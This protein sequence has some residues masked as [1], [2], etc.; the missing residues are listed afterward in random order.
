[1]NRNERGG[2]GEGGVSGEMLREMAER[3]ERGREIQK[4]DE[5]KGVRENRAAKGREVETN[6]VRKEM[7]VRGMKAWQ[8]S[9][10]GEER[11]E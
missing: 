6:E 11:S 10:R 4:G 8:R 1:M 9:D 7:G 5:C 3:R 2:G